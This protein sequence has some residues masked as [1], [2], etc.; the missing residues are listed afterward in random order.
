MIFENPGALWLLLALPPLLLGL[1]L[2]GWKA[3]KEAVVTF[4]LS[5][6]R[7]MRKQVE[8]YITA[9]VL[10]TLLIVTL[11]LPNVTYYV[12]AAAEKTGEVALL[13]DV[14]RS[15]AAR[16]N[17][18]S[19]SRLERV[20][21]VLYEI[22]DSM[23][24]LGQVKIS[25]HGFTTTARSHVPLVGKED[26]P[27]LKESIKKV[28]DIN[29]TPGD[30]TGLGE[31]I[32]NVIGKFSEGEQAKIIILF[33][34]GEPYFLLR[35]GLTYHEENNVK[36]AIEDAT[37]EGVKV[38]TVGFGEQE[39]ARIPLYDSDGEFTGDYTKLLGIDYVSYFEEEFL[40]DIADQTEGEY[41]YEDNLGGLVEYIIENLD[42]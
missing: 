18:D 11:A 2:W 15:M 3:K 19:S 6:R 31:S 38:I 16:K 30:G 22:I 25:L 26:Y 40:K 23:E 37:E 5:L 7:L 4:P 17:P 8:K 1:G 35:Q 41:F 9:G 27:Y 14:S 28:L 34:D 12:S 39:G 20:K 10:M 24:E 42:K 32:Q 36:H 21:P 29:S 13:V 33:S